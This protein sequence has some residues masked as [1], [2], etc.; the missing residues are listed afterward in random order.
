MIGLSC[1]SILLAAFISV[2][3]N[4]GQGPL[5]LYLGSS[6]PASQK[7]LEQIIAVSGVRWISLL[8]DGVE[9]DPE[10]E[11]RVENF[12]NGLTLKI[13]SNV[14][15]LRC[16]EN[17]DWR[18][19]VRD[20]MNVSPIIIVRPENYGPV[21]EEIDFLATLGYPQRIIVIRTDPDCETHLPYPL[22]K[23]VMDEQE[24]FNWISLTASRPRLFRKKIKAREILFEDIN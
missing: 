6:N 5:A 2:F 10:A 12:L 1:L 4:L 23:C 3:L 17:V 11:D 24:V 22:N 21:R 16:N 15:S 8:N 13:R 19:I 20:F 7:I 14:W 18:T 9:L